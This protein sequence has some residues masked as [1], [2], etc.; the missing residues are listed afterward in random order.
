[1][2]IAHLPPRAACYTPAEARL[3]RG[4]TEPCVRGR[5][6]RGA[7]RANL[8]HDGVEGMGLARGRRPLAAGVRALVRAGMQRGLRLL[9]QGQPA[10]GGEGPRRQA[11]RQI[12]E[13]VALRPSLQRDPRAALDEVALACGASLVAWLEPTGSGREASL[14]PR[15]VVRDRG[16]QGPLAL[17]PGLDLPAQAMAAAASRVVEDLAKTPAAPTHPL[18]AAEGLRAGMA[19]VGAVGPEV[20]GVLLVGWRQPRRLALSEREFV[21]DAASL[22]A[23]AAENARLYRETQRASAV[24]ERERLA[25]EMHDGLAQTMTYLRLKAEAALVYARRPES[26]PL[27]VASLE[28]IRGASLQAL[29]E[30]RQAIM[31]LKSPVMGG[32]FCRHL[33]EYLRAWSLTNGVCAQLQLPDGPLVLGEDTRFQVVRIIQEALANVRQHASAGSV[34]VRLGREDG[35]LCVSVADDGVGLPAGTGP[36]PGHFGLSILQERAS[37]I[38]GRI[39]IRSRGG[40]GTEVLL[41]VPRPSPDDAPGFGVAAGAARPW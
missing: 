14:Q 16:T 13:L 39:D 38:G 32:D 27:V 18:L 23:I 1:M 15:V 9:P 24:E 10:R 3:A 29:G 22:L 28:A 36:G 26:V 40:G 2:T 5:R 21:E 8:G 33:D 25:R 41:R 37:V 11:L 6:P 12:T 4:R 31:D 34:W 30:V 20:L 19:A 7:P 35:G 17:R